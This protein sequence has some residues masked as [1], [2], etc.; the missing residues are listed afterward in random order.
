MVGGD[1]IMSPQN[2]PDKET[3]LAKEDQLSDTSI[4]EGAS[5]EKALATMEKPEKIDVD[6]PST[7]INRELSWLSFARRVLALAEDPD[8]PLLERVKFAGIM[9]MLYDEFA[10]KRMGGTQTQ[11]RK[12]KTQ[13][14]GQGIP[15]WPQRRGGIACL[16]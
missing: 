6:S 5:I 9:G 10:M 16:P 14:E 1:K 2:H 3:L 12:K 11:D 13:E 4:E 15:R 8:L 7:L